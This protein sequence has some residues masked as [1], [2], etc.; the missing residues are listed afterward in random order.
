M[1][2]VLSSTY[3][4]LDNGY[5]G[6]GCQGQGHKPGEGTTGTDGTCSTLAAG[7]T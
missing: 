6:W 1:G 2:C 4:I 7:D 5:D 3:G